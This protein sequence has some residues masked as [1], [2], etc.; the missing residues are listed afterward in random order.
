MIVLDMKTV[1]LANVIIGKVVMFMLLYQNNNK[2]RH[3]VL[4]TELDIAY[5]RHGMVTSLNLLKKTICI[6]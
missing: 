2:F 3:Y 6:S 4:G 5:R 1:I